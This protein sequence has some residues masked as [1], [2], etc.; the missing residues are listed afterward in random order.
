MLPTMAQSN[1][2]AL[3]LRLR[4]GVTGCLFLPQE[5]NGGYSFGNNAALRPALQSAHP[6]AY[7]LLLNPDTVVRLVPSNPGRFH[8]A[9][10]QCGNGGK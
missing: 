3:R 6:P 4:V 1:K 8:G 5:H 9:A 10:F 2:L 7:F